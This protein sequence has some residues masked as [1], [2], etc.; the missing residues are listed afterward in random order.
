MPR[1]PLCRL[2]R[3]T[4]RAKHA[5]RRFWARHNPVAAIAH[6]RMFILWV[7]EVRPMRHILACIAFAS[8]A[9]LASAASAGTGTVHYLSCRADNET[10]PAIF[11]LDEVSKKVCDRD[12]GQKWFA[13]TEFDAAVVE[14]S[15]GASTKVIYRGGS[16]N[17]YEPNILLLNH[18]G[19]GGRV[20]APATPLCA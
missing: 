1:N 17:T 4:S 9:A 8:V 2:S 14:W 13:P 15:A 7:D 10:A 20:A 6:A 16:H 3:R 12:A 19:H 5:R 11:G 18:V